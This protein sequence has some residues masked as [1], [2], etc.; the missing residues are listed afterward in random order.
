[1]KKLSSLKQSVFSVVV[2]ALLVVQPTGVFSQ[3]RST[4][5]SNYSVN[6]SDKNGKSTIRVSDNGKDFKI[7]YEGEF[8][9][10]DDDKDITAI[11]EGGFIDITKSSF[12]N[13]RRVVIESDRSGD[14]IRKFYVGRSQRDYNPEGREWLAEVLPDIV[15]STT[16]G[17]KS[18]VAR[19]YNRGGAS[20]VL[21]EIRSMKS[22]YVKSRY[23]RLLLERNLSN[24]ELVNVIEASGEEIKSDHYLAKILKTNQKAFLANSQTINAYI[25]ASGSLKSDH[26]ATSVLKHVINDS[27]ISDGQ[28]ER[29]LD[30]AKGVKSDHYVTQILTEIMENRDLNSQNVAKI[31]SLSKD[32]KSDHYK[33]QVLKKV[34]NDEGMSAN[35]YSA[36]IATVADIKSDHYMTS[37]VKEMMKKGDVA[38]NS[39]DLNDLLALVR[40]HVRSD[41]YSATIYKSLAR[42]ELSESQM[43]ATL[44]AAAASIKSDHYLSNVLLA[45]SDDVK[46][47]SERVKSA[48]RTAAKS[49]K[50]DTY[51][52]RAAKAID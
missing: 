7:E 27:S 44:N 8:T 5:K 50:S 48:Y 29:L 34:I 28:M 30:I 2:L 1:M 4:K 13:K 12:G 40:T 35:A 52:G 22:D 10:S 46:R 31:I 39:S 23:F 42:K 20:A 24:G 16:L 19:F 26:Y 41:N 37:V 15:R 25:A 21:S 6:M 11:T 3:K 18:R 51:Y 14:L 36:L 47:S 33:T 49:I 45:F 17:A 38:A 43:I 32:I 9:L